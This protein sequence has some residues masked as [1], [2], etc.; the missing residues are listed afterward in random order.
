MSKAGDH[1]AGAPCTADYGSAANLAS[2]VIPGFNNAITLSW[3]QI[4]VIWVQNSNTALVRM[5]YA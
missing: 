3:H 2:K 4:N 1:S 5:S